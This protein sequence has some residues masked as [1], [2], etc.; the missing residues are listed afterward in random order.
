MIPL[1]ISSAGVAGVPPTAR[2][3]AAILLVIIFALL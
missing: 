2:L 3:D 1:S